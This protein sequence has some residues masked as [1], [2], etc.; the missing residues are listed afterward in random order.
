MSFK[1]FSFDDR[2]YIH[3]GLDK[4]L[5]I[6]QIAKKL[7]RPDSSIAR[8]IKRNRFRIADRSIHMVE[9][10]NLR[11][12]HTKHGCGDMECNSDCLNCYKICGTDTCPDFC[13]AQC[14]H[15]TGSPFACNGCDKYIE[16]KTCRFPKKS[17]L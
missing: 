15:I 1:H 5:S 7:K 3:E 13:E 12:C 10:A 11:N 16:K 6:H 14:P 17:L 4:K 9:C 2:V 8:E